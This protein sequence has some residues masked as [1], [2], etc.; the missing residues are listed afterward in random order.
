MDDQAEGKRPSR[1]AGLGRWWNGLERWQQWGVLAIGAVLIYLLPV[2]NPPLITS[3]PSTD[4]PITCANM[5]IYALAALGLNVVVGQAGLL[6]LGYV[7]FFA[8]G[9]YVAALWTS[10]DS[11]F[12]HLPFLWTLPLA[13]I[14]TV[15][16]GII[17]GIPTLRLRGDYLAIVTLGFGEIIRLLA[18]LIP[19]LHGQTG[20]QNIGAPPGTSD[21]GN[22]I[23]ANNKGIPWYWL[24]VSV[25]ILMMLLLGNLERSRAG[26]A[27]IAIREDEDAAE[28]M[29]V[30]TFKFKLWAFGIGAALGGLSGALFAGLNGFVNNQKFDVQTSMLF[31]AAVVL[32]GAGNKFGAVLG[33]ALIAYIPLRFTGLA[34]YKILIFGIILV[35][36]MIFRPQ[37]LFGARNHLLAYASRARKWLTNRESPTGPVETA[38]ESGS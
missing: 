15:F 19:A 9:A 37:G 10:S 20:F 21:D 28:I 17:L 8:V 11:T 13:M 38:K 18:T 14:V 12:V 5:A 24:T 22:P 29:G 26:R 35:L 33:G 30:P 34:E 16:F 3:E 7:G 25:I 31:L 23:F 27:W 6:D 4:F 1:F 32:G 36:L 2:I